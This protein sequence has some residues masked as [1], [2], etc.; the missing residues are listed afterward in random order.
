[1]IYIAH[2]S[3][4]CLKDLRER[5]AKCG[6][7]ASEAIV[8]FRETAVKAPGEF[9]CSGSVMDM[10]DTAPDLAPPKTK[11]APRGTV[12]GSLMAGLVT[13]T[14]R[15]LPLPEPIINF[16]LSQTNTIANMLAQKK[17]AEAEGT[18]DDADADVDIELDAEGSQGRLL[19]STQFWEELEGLC[20]EAGGEW[21]GAADRIWSFGP[22]RFGANLLLDPAG[23][24][25]TRWVS[26]TSETVLQYLKRWKQVTG[27]RTASC[28]RES[29]GQIDQGSD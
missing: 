23:K 16:L 12:H 14:I 29:R 4:R 7:Q 26:E 27:T 8:P 20:K 15:A 19:T 25:T 6:I 22:K 1:M 21:V 13:Y 2:L 3:Q 28:N 18:I 11:D 5:F 24:G 9:H 10:A 17:S